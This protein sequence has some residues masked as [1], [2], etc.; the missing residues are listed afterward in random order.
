[1]VDINMLNK[2]VSLTE[3]KTEKDML[4]FEILNS[5]FTATLHIVCDVLVGFAFSV[6]TPFLG[7]VILCKRIAS[8]I[9]FTMLE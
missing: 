2:N 6:P 1:M 7:F 9:I 3:Y 5:K 8:K 4:T